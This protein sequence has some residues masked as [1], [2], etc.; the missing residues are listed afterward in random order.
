MDIGT[1]WR[2]GQRQI[3]WMGEGLRR[4][5]G[6]PIF[7]LRP[8]AQLAA[9][10]RERGIEVVDI[11]PTVAEFGPW[12]ILLLRRIIAR[13]RV[14]ILH[15]QSGHT[16]ALAALA[17]AGTR[18][19]VVFARRTTFPLRDNTGTRWKYA[20]ADRVIS[21]SRAGVSALLG[22]GVDHARIEVIP[23]GIPLGRE[24]CARPAAPELLASFGVGAG[25]PL[26]VM[27]GALTAVKDPLTYVRAV[28]AAR[29]A[30]PELRA[31]LVGEGQLRGAV[32]S[33]VRALGL[34]DAFR[35]TGFR[36]DHDSF[37]A[38][39][40]VA[41][42]SSTLEG[43]PGA[44]MDALA[45]GRPI[46]ATAVGGIPEMVHHGVSGLLTPPGDAD[47]LGGSIAR[48]L[49]DPQLAARLSAAARARAQEFSIE[50]TVARTIAAYERVLGG[51]GSSSRVSR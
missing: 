10:A 6:R 1:G 28:A 45:L 36:D 34:D 49:Q 12:T 16:L 29:R 19:R 47:A 48:I 17:A 18:A 27:V 11:D 20:R 13:E 41:C 3:L 37:I 30:L 40:D 21:V 5:G 33:E 2:G 51:D 4:H 46:A 38:A 26:V 43:T 39:G 44:L 7:A 22:A 50:T 42:L 14:D 23:S 32:E 31:L 24:T 9:R 25:A 15:P 8:G 35:L